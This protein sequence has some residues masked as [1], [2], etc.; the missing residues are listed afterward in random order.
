[1]AESINFF[2]KTLRDREYNN[3]V[4]KTREN[5]LLKK[6]SI[7]EKELI[8]KLNAKPEKGQKFNVTMMDM[9]ESLDIA[10]KA[11]AVKELESNLRQKQDE[12][13]QIISE[14]VKNE[15]IQIQESLKD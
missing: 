5:V 9:E 12:M 4:Y 15:I 13:S 8:E 1:M 10:T 11:L 14:K 7:L 3:N 6:I 2:D